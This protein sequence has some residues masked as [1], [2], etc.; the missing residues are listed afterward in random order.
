MRM[1]VGREQISS[2]GP[3]SGK[4]GLA[5]GPLCCC[6][7]TQIFILQPGPTKVVRGERTR[8]RKRGRHE[9]SRAGDCLCGVQCRLDD[10]GLSWGWLLCVEKIKY[11]VERRWSLP[12]CVK[13][14]VS[15][16]FVGRVFQLLDFLHLN[17]LKFY[18]RYL[19]LDPGSRCQKR[20]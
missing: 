18:Q 2:K 13:K 5:C 7:P 10:I 9:N 6:H 4:K 1:S 20:F 17:S 16:E 19:K 3:A 8:I 14:S 11:N 12:L 15:A